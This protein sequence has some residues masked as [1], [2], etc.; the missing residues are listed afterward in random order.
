MRTIA[1]LR[2][3]QSKEKKKEIYAERG[4]LIDPYLY[5]SLKRLKK[6][7]ACKKACKVEI[8]HKVPVS[9]GGSNEKDNLLALCK[10]CHILADKLNDSGRF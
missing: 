4:R 7:Q 1:A 6:C 2:R 5:A 9:K 8:H 10:K 3:W